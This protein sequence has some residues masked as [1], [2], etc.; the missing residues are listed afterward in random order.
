MVEVYDPC[1]VPSENRA[2]T[3]PR[4]RTLAGLK[5]GILDNNKV[6]AGVLLERTASL[7]CE[8]GAELS[9]KGFKEVWGSTAPPEVIESLAHCE[10]VVFA[11][12]G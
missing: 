10:A 12:G 7:L 8:R 5:F 9:V 3:A 6:N 1:G 4:P 2:T 11:H